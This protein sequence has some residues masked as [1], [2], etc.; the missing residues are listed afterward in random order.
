VIGPDLLE[1]SYGLFS[2]RLDS[3]LQTNDR[4]LAFLREFWHY[5]S[6]DIELKFIVNG[7]PQLV[8]ESHYE[9]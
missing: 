9:A 1:Y 3:S 7:N 6:L 2:L 4:N 8:K 5:E